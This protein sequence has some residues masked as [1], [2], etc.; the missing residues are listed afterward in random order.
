MIPNLGVGFPLQMLSAVI[1][2]KRSY[3]TMLLTEQSVH[4]RFPQP[5]PLVLWSAPLKNQRLLRIET[6]LSYDVLN[7]TN[8]AL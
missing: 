8:A 6:E 1:L 7:P 5:G 3:P 2:W 4:Q